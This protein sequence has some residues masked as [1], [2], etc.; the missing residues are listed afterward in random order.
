L[1]PR[2]RGTGS[3]QQYDHRHVGGKD[4]EES[5]IGVARGGQIYDEPDALFYRRATMA[6]KV[7]A[8]LEAGAKVRQAHYFGALVSFVK[9]APG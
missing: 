2:P 3:D 1:Y 6:L 8:K 7:I 9:F 4:D 5:V